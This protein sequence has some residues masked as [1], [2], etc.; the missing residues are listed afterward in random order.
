[1]WLFFP[2]PKIQWAIWLI[3]RRTG[4]VKAILNSQQKGNA[5]YGICGGYQMM[6][7]EIHDPQHVEGEIDFMPGARA[8]TCCYYANGRKANCA[9]RIHFQE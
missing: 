5:V 1:M 8:F 2:V 7:R 3:W 9:K 6:G 4:L